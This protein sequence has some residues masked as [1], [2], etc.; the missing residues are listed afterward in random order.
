MIPTEEASQ[1]PGEA[2]P[3]APPGGQFL[4]EPKEG[5]K[6]ATQKTLPGRQEGGGLCW[7]TKAQ[8]LECQA[9][10]LFPAGKGAQKLARWRESGK[11]L[12]G[13]EP[14]PGLDPTAS[15]LPALAWTLD[16]HLD[17]QSSHWAPCLLSSSTLERAG[18]HCLP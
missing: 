8:H 17:G 5:R 1:Q 12:M 7:G 9:S 14:W 11:S 3:P 6:E 18:C 13:T 4:L 16:G 2:A 10:A 15:L